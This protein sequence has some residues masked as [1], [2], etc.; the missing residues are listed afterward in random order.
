MEGYKGF[1]KG[2]I[3]RGKQY[4]ENT[5]F[6]EDKAVICNS[7]M[8]FC[9]EPMDVLDF[10]P[11]ESEFAKVEALDEAK[12]D[13]N[14]KYV[15][16]KLKVGAKISFAEL[17][18]AQVEIDVEKAKEEGS[19]N[20]AQG[21][22]GHAAA[23]GECGH[24]AAQGECGHA[25]AQGYYGHAAA[26]GECGHAAAQGKRGHA[27]AQGYRGH[28]AAQGKRGHAAAQG[29]EGHAAAQGERGHAAAQGN[30]GH[31]AAQGECGHAAAQGERG[32]AAAQGECG[33]AAAQG[34]RG[35]AAAQGKRGHA[36]AQGDEG[37]AEVGGKEAI[38]AAF[39]IEGKA[40]ACLGSWIMLAEWKYENGRWHIADV[41]TAKI[42]GEKLKPDT[43]YMLKNGEFEEAGE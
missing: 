42:D 19:G 13:D 5:V 40:R 10:Y 33:H 43:W 16:K 32:H 21:Y 4:A 17:V 35:H 12:T 36:A 11:P 8:H 23:Q 34:K 30:E 31:A 27:A 38:A 9:K 29:N 28:A 7:G 18:K 22:Y 37:H 1:E 26:Q 3:C 2:L 25:A 41:K 15:T 24:A 20:F 6:E 14:R 39:G